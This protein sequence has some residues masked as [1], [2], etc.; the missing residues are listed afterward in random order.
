MLRE[1]SAMNLSPETFGEFI[2]PY[3]QR[4]LDEFGGGA[5]H[6]CGRGDHWIPRVPEMRGIYGVNLS[7]PEL[8]NMETVYRYTVDRGIVLLGLRRDAAE[9]ALARGRDLRGLVHCW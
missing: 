3:N 8:N 2:E 6:Y 7:Q 5:T 9:E 1:D 4:L